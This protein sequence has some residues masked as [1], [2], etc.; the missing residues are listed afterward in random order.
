MRSKNR[1]SKRNGL[2][3]DSR[4][5][6]KLDVINRNQIRRKESIKIEDLRFQPYFIPSRDEVYIYKC[7]DV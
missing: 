4:L 6:R 3:L 5:K 1:S 2:D 7:L